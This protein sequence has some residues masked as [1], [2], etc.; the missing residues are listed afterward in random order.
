MSE[1]DN[2]INKRRAH[3]SASIA[4]TSIL[5]WA[6]EGVNLVSHYTGVA[7]DVVKD[8]LEKVAPSDPEA[9]IQKEV[10]SKVNRDELIQQFE[11]AGRAF[12]SKV[13][14]AAGTTGSAAWAFL[15][16]ASGQISTEA[17]ARLETLDD[18]ADEETISYDDSTPP[19]VDGEYTEST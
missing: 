18:T 7:K 13:A 14:T 3:K 8:Q 9:R 10:V 11:S 4:N 12:G 6:K 17:K 16:S 5:D 1:Y 15:K 19:I 2:A